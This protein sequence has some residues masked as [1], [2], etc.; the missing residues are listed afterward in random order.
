MKSSAMR[1]LRAA[2]S[3]WMHCKKAKKKF[4]EVDTSVMNRKRE[5]GKVFTS[6]F[7][8]NST[9]FKDYSKETTK[10]VAK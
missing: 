8:V 10:Q 5:L 2:R 3:R 9:S 4:V 1:M 6:A 7:R